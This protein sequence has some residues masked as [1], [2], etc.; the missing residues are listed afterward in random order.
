MITTSSGSRL[1]PIRASTELFTVSLF[2]RGRRVNSFAVLLDSEFVHC[3]SHLRKMMTTFQQS[4]LKS[5]SPA[6]DN[7]ETTKVRREV[8]R[9][10]TIHHHT[11]SPVTLSRLPFSFMV[12][13]LLRKTLDRGVYSEHVHLYIPRL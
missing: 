12:H 2:R 9:S 5:C 11:S 3:T 1:Q 4:T 8:P 6:S 13:C 7:P 10:S